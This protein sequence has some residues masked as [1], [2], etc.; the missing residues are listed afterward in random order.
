[1]VEAMGRVD[2]WPRANGFFRESHASTGL[3][4]QTFC[5]LLLVHES[6]FGFQD[7]LNPKSSPFGVLLDQP[8]RVLRMI[9]MGM[10]LL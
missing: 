7:P 2:G 6:P 9:L 10:A 8:A 4:R 5:G 3:L 1:M